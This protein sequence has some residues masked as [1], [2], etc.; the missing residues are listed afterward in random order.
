LK[1]DR[2]TP[3]DGR[4][5]TATVTDLEVARQRAYLVGVGNHR[6]N[7]DE[8]ERSLAELA[9]LTDTAGSDPIRLRAVRIRET[10]D[11][12]TFIG[13]GKAEE[14][15][16][17]ARALDADVVVFD[18]DLTPAQ[19]RNL[20]TIF[21]CDVVDRVAL[22][23]DIFAQH[24]TSRAGRI[25]VEL[26]LLR[27]HL[28]RLRGKGTELSRLG[29][30]I[31][32]RGPGETKLE[33]DRRRILERISRLEHDLQKIRRTRETQRQARRKSAYPLVALVGYTNAGKSTLLNQLTD[34]GVLVE[35]R[36][37][38]TL[39]STVRRYR[40]S[41]GLTILLSDTVGFVRHLPHQLVEAFQSTLV[42]VVQAHLLLHVVDAADPDAETQI[43]A[44][45][46]V[47]EEIGAE[48]VPEVLVLNKADVAGQ[49]K[50]RRLSELYPEAVSVSALHG[51][52][53]AELEDAL[54]AALADRTVELKLQ[55]PY[56]R[57]DALAALHREADLL[58]EEHGDEGTEVLARV[59][60]AYVGWFEEFV[61]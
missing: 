14:L 29:G 51:T 60:A 58:R 9:L 46:E 45:R 47:L 27:Y 21:R 54:A 3:R 59:P 55:I 30:G 37:F 33:T 20:E 17:E 49:T 7:A 48:T 13:R 53:R 50:M 25:Q 11:P 8:T 39:D 18:N 26:A 23:L 12:A 24:A 61:I 57:G 28:P 19:Q 56:E 43:A 5:L 42:E 40:L 4:R 1:A 35:D 6:R 31:G 22:I 34:A 44:V 38:S 15:A 52:G 10:Y 16:E 36:L 41:N 32:T 2:T